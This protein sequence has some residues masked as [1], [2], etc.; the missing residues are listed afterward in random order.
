M[1]S[2]ADQP[3]FYYTETY[4]VAELLY[5]LRDVQE[6]EARVGKE[7]IMRWKTDDQRWKNAWSTPTGALTDSS[8]PPLS[9]SHTPARSNTITPTTEVEESPPLDIRSSF[10]SAP[11]QYDYSWIATALRSA[12]K[13]PS[14]LK[15]IA[16]ASRKFLA[17]KKPGLKCEQEVCS[18]N[19]LE[20][21]PGLGQKRTKRPSN[22]DGRYPEET[23]PRSPGSKRPRVEGDSLGRRTTDE[24]QPKAI[25]APDSFTMADNHGVN[26]TTRIPLVQVIESSR[27]AT[28][29]RKRRSRRLQ[30]LP[31]VLQTS[32]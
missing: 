18:S 16:E 9:N 17:E 14:S 6:E 3:P 1:N 4:I 24:D 28:A 26:A 32:M 23:R 22:D 13:P 11:R 27:R 10:S 12:Y 7:A 15:I 30:G 21:G 25:N 5:R 31:P 8:S 29:A 19:S 20:N 2:P